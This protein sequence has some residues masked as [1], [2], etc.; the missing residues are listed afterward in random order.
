MTDEDWPRTGRDLGGWTQDEAV[1]YEVAC[2]LLT[3]MV[4]WCSSEI[5]KERARPTPDVAVIQR[6]ESDSARYAREQRELDPADDAEVVRVTRVY[7]EQLREHY[8]QVR[9]SGEAGG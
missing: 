1:A 9:A 7:G 5:A 2:E 6:W 4:A 8:E 3:G